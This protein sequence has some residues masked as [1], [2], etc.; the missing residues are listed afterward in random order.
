MNDSTLR[1]TSFV[2]RVWWEHPNQAAPIFRGQ[3]KDV[4][5]GVSVYFD[6][7]A[8]LQDFIC[9]SCGCTSAHIY[10]ATAREQEPD[11]AITTIAKIFRGGFK[12]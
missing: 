8:T 3:V 2:V 1:E 12:P 7:L 10:V 4:L 6:H 5:S 11:Q 9:Q